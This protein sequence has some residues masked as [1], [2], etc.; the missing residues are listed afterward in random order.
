MTIIYF[1]RTWGVITSFNTMLYEWEII[2][3]L[4]CIFLFNQNLPKRKY[5]WLY[6]TIGTVLMLGWGFLLGFLRDVWPDSNLFKIFA[7]LSLYSF[8]LFITFFCYNE[9]HWSHV[10]LSWIT[11]LCVREVIDASYALICMSTGQNPRLGIIQFIDNDIFNLVM[12]DLM[13]IVFV[14]VLYFFLRKRIHLVED[15]SISLR[16]IIISLTMLFAL[17]LIKTFVVINSESAIPLYGCCEALISLVS[18]LLLFVRADILRES[19]FKVEQRIMDQ[20]LAENKK[21]YQSL[22]TNIDIVNMKAH[23]LKHQ[24]EKYQDKLT[25]EEV[26]SLRN[27]VDIYDKNIRT[28]SPVLDT[29][30]Y[31]EHLVCDKHQIQFTY[32]CDGHQLENFSSSQLYYLFSNIID[33]AIDACKDVPV[34]NRIISF[35][36]RQKDNQ[37]V[38]DSCNYFEGSRNIQDGVMETT[39]KNKAHHGYGLKSIK[40]IVEQNKGSMNI[41]TENNMFF[42]VINLPIP[43]KKTI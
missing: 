42:M 30:L 40:M 27:A 31:V 17:V 19:S 4:V 25:Q 39:K 3:H 32:L 33:N 6:C 15:R 26:E 34:E 11:A 10:F 35:N 5:T 8:S 43:E 2:Q 7:T 22:K 21:Q 41:H 23:D 1:L 20:V 37:I 24:L 18:A 29:V 16:I 36:I 12:Y 28:G 14:I 13:H 38:I 9:K